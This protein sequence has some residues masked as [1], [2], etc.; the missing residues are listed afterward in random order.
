MFVSM[1]CWITSSW[2]FGRRWLQLVSCLFIRLLMWR[3][4]K[5]LSCYYNLIHYWAH[6]V[7]ISI[8]E[9]SFTRLPKEKVYIGLRWWSLIL[10]GWESFWEFQIMI[11]WRKLRVINY[12]SDLK[13]LKELEGILGRY[14]GKRSVNKFD[15]RALVF[16][17]SQP[18]NFESLKITTKMNF[19]FLKK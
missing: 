19:R 17:W 13:D 16:N 7:L 18:K 11:N 4:C 15:L 14:R 10:E 5:L 3:F 9:C 2:L 6:S 1:S 12:E 8:L